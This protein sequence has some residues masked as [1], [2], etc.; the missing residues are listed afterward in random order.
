MTP[1]S[2]LPLVQQLLPMAEQLSRELPR[3]WIGLLAVALVSLPGSV[4]AVA[5]VVQAVQGRRTGRKVD[6]QLEKVDGLQQDINHANQTLTNVKG[7]VTN[8]GSNLAATVGD[9]RREMRLLRGFVENQPNQE[10]FRKLGQ[11]VD[12]LDTRFRNSGL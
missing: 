4:A 6:S 7:Q 11:K 5:S 2:G 9:M 8:G 1:L 12:D 10:D 3:D